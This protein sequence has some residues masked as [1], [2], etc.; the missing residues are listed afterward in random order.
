LW[1]DVARDLQ[2]R[3]FA[4]IATTCARMHPSYESARC[5]FDPSD[6]G[7]LTDSRNA[8]W[9]VPF[10]TTHALEA[11]LTLRQVFDP[12]PWED[13]PTDLLARRRTVTNQVRGQGRLA[14]IEWD[15]FD[16]ADDALSDTRWSFTTGQS[17]TPESLP[18]GSIR[19]GAEALYPTIPR[20]RNANRVRNV[21]TNRTQLNHN[22]TVDD[23]DPLNPMRLRVIEPN[24]I[25]N[26]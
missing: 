15:A 12:T 2:R 10:P 1:Q 7:W 25:I 24:N 22:A 11:V 8:I 14:P 17:N 6:E 21:E 3:F 5:Y 16:A 13:E 26:P 9:P 19:G 18:D 4:A 20:K 23:H